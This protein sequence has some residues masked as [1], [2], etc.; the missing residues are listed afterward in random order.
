MRRAGKEALFADKHLAHIDGSKSIHVLFRRDCIDDSLL[1]D[2]LRKRKL[3]ENTM[4][5]TIGIKLGDKLKKIFLGRFSCKANLARIHPCFR[6]SFLLG[7][8]IAD[9]GGII[10]HKDN[11]KTR[12]N[13]L[14]CL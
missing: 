1:A 2:M 12:L 5:G 4:N 11:C 7:R 10:P 14:F 8:H 3:N 9:A 6:A 13:T